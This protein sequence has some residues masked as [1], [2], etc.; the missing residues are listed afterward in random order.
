[1]PD[2]QTSSTQLRKPYIGLVMQ[3]LPPTEE[4]EG[5]VWRA[6]QEK[7]DSIKQ[8]GGKPIFLQ[9][10]RSLIDEYVSRLDGL[11]VPGNVLDI[12]DPTKLTKHGKKRLTYEMELV[13]AMLKAGKP[14]LGICGGF[15]VMAKLL[16]AKFIND[17]PTELPGAIDHHPHNKY[18]EAAHGI[19]I[20]PGSFMHKATGGASSAQIGSIHHQGFTAMP[21]EFSI[22]AKAP[23]GVVEAACIKDNSGKEIFY[24]V[25]F[26]PEIRNNTGIV[27]PDAKFTELD[28]INGNIFKLFV[29][30]A[31]EQPKP[32]LTADLVKRIE[33]LHVLEDVKK[34]PYMPDWEGA[35]ALM[36]HATNV[37]QK[38]AEVKTS[39]VKS[40]EIKVDEVQKENAAPSL[41]NLE[42]LAARSSVSGNQRVSITINM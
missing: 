39:A 38:Q 17:I 28:A 20:T 33:A 29:D 23:D 25:Q 26:H 27:R 32:E 40:P 31:K 34:L 9:H 5:H 4:E 41:T 15:Q 21:P 16:D 7:Y 1:M 36:P 11:V 2:N 30:R 22:S 8:A 6:S 13:T 18:R 3:V 35:K 19:T 42:K 24:G 10:K 37:D 12:D 14:V